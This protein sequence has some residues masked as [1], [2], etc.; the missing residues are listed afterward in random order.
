MTPSVN[1]PRMASLILM[2]RPVSMGRA[3]GRSG[4][5]LESSDGH[6]A[7]KHRALAAFPGFSHLGSG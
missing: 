5:Q 4:Y 1:L 3:S 7:Y 6:A 2:L